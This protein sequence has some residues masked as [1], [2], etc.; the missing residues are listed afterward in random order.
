M[1]NRQVADLAYIVIHIYILSRCRCSKQKNIQNTNELQPE[2]EQ[3]EPL[4]F[5]FNELIKMEGV[6]AYGL[7]RIVLYSRLI[8][9]LVFFLNILLLWLLPLLLFICS[10][11]PFKIFSLQIIIFA[12]LNDPELVLRPDVYRINQSRFE[13]N[14]IN[15]TNLLQLF[16]MQ[17]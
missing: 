6:H 8:T 10:F 2:I 1:P 16:I 7:N 13:M 5:H 3:F 9:D 11:V 14:S 15:Q 12:R 17:P 4:L